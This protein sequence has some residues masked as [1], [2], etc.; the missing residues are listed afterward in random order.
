MGGILTSES[1]KPGLWG[2]G[3]GIDKCLKQ[4]FRAW[5][6][7]VFGWIVDY[8]PWY[9]GVKAEKGS[10]NIVVENFEYMNEELYVFND[11]HLFIYLFINKYL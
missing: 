1:I 8:K 4:D 9:R 6:A 2:G 7:M 3:N 10:E 5:P 11:V